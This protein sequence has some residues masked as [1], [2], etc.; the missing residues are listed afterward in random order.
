MTAESESSSSTINATLSDWQQGDCVVGDDLWFVYRVAQDF[1]L[2]VEGVQAATFVESW[3]KYLSPKG[4]FQ[5]ITGMLTT[6][7]DMTA[8][9]LVESDQ[10]DLDHLSSAS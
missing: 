5:S 4:R 7:R 10:P 8:Q 6:L 1:V 9:D 2:T 3:L